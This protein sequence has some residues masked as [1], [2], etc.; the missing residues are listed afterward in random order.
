MGWC[1][2]L[3]AVS[4]WCHCHPHHLLVLAYPH[5]PGK[6]TVKWVSVCLTKHNK[7]YKVTKS[8]TAQ[9]LRQK[10]LQQFQSQSSSESSA[11]TTG[12]GCDVWDPAVVDWDR[13]KNIDLNCNATTSSSR[14][15]YLMNTQSFYN[16]FTAL[17]S[18]PPGWAGARRKL[19]DFMVQGKINKSRHHSAGRHSMQTNQR[20]TPPSPIFYRLDA[21]P[22]A[23]TTVSK[24][25][26]QLAHSD[27]MLEFSSMA[28]PAPSPYLMNSTKSC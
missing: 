8:T 20:P 24:H 1:C 15:I 2:Y 13:P 28:L 11:R 4:S 6:E 16:R 3:S 25:W 21:L 18:V 14:I 26:R 27:K 7:Q 23:Q 19:L 5:C 22:V 12:G 9:K 10:R 17:F